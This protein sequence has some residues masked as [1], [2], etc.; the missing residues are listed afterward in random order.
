[1]KYEYQTLKLQTDSFFNV[2][3]PGSESPELDELINQL[4]REGWELVS[5]ES[6]IDSA[7]GHYPSTRAFILFFKRPL[8]E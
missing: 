3:A 4:G 1:M 2:D 5:T 6:I 7:F 8:A